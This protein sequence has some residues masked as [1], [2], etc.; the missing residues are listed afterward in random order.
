M[1]FP[2][3]R[4]AMVGDAVIRGLR[5]D[6]NLAAVVLDVAKQIAAA[7]G[8]PPNAAG[9]ARHLIRIGSEQ[10]TGVSSMEREGFFRGIAE[11]KRKFAEA[12]AE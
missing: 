5:M 3:K 2:R 10:W 11:A 6:T 7:T 12:G 4:R 8:E 1:P 9:A